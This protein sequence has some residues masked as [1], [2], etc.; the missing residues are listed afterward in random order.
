MTWPWGKELLCIV[1]QNLVAGYA[2]LTGHL[3]SFSGVCYGK[4][5]ILQTLRR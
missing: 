2:N 1:I 3:L 4:V 5:F